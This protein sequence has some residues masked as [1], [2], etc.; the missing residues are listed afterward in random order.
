MRIT[1]NNAKTE[2]T[3]TPW[4]FVVDRFPYRIGRTSL[5]DS[6]DVL[7]KNDLGLR[8]VDPLRVGRNHCVIEKEG[9]EIYVRD[10][11][12]RGGCVVNGAHIGENQEDCQAKL[13]MGENVLVIGGPK[14]QVQFKLILTRE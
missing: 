11:G 14:S 1:A 7:Q 12:S 10:R 2:K 13:K 8:N 4:D 5:S 3:C 6:P 9:E